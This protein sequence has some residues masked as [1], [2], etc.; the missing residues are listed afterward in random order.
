MRAS[1][2]LRA[3]HGATGVE[4]GVLLAILVV[5]VTVLLAFVVYR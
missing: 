2:R 3:E 5:A 4:Y 1:Q